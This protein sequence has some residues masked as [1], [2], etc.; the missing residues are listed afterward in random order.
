MHGQ[1]IPARELR[2]HKSGEETPN[3]LENEHRHAPVHV[4]S[5]HVKPRGPA[6]EIVRSRIAITKTDEK[7]PKRAENER[8]HA[9]VHVTSAHV[10][11]RGPAAEIVRSRIA[12]TKTDEKRSAPNFTAHNLA[13]N[14]CRLNKA[15]AFLRVSP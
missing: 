15:Y 3:R 13:H 6:A 2:L 7:R 4:T 11:P 10:K 5:A 14:L 1:K 12:I 9:P 8:S